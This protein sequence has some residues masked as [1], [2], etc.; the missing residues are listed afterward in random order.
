MQAKQ[1]LKYHRVGSYRTGSHF[2]AEI[3]RSALSYKHQP[4]DVFI[5]TY[6]KSGTTWMQCILYQIYTNAAPITSIKDFAEQ[7]PFLERTGAEGLSDLPRPGSAIKTHMLYDQDRVSQRA[8]YIYIARN[9]YDVC[10]SFF[11]HYK[12]LPVYHFEDGTF[13]QF[14]EMFMRGDVD[15][16]DYFDH[17]L[18]WYEHRDDPNVFFV[19]YEDL[20]QDTRFWVQKVADFVGHQFGDKLRRNPHVMD[21]ILDA[22]SLANVRELVRLEKDY[23]RKVIMETPKD[24]MPR[25]AALYLDMGGGLLKKPAAGQFVRKGIVGDWKNYFTD[26]QFQRLKQKFRERCYGTDAMKLWKNLD[27]C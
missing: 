7:L 9:P 16:G 27:L 6:P 1:V 17:L 24:R 11:N 22:T 15:F 12:H 14:F 18:S 4:G 3:L 5:V 2:P 21:R 20:K 19:T 13:E 10:V 26:A 25:W 8:K 23:Q